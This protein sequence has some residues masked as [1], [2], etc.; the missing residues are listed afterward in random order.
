MATLTKSLVKHLL[1]LISIKLPL[2]IVSIPILAIALL[3]YLKDKRCKGDLHDQRLPDFLKWL[4]NGDV[5]DRAYGLNGDLGYQLKYSNLESP[6]T[7]YIM[8]LNWLAFRNPINYFQYHKLG[9]QQEDIEDLIYISERATF[10]GEEV[11]DWSSPGVRE[12]D[13]LLT[14]GKT[15]FERY[16]IYQYPFW[17]TKC[18][19]ARIGWKFS[20]I[21][22]IDRAKHFQWVFTVQPIKDYRGVNLY[23]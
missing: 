15:A 1:T 11:G 3:F 5:L 21:S 14:T 23:I 18:F 4:D 9:I 6:W 7:L 20:N 10:I 16:W 22:K 8:R 17:P 13:I 19:R 2:Q 12:V